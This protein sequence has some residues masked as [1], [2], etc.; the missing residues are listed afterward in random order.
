MSEKVLFVL[1]GASKEPKVID[2]LWP[3]AHSW[4]GV[5]CPPKT[6]YTFCTHIYTL[7]RDLKA[8]PDLDLLGLLKENDPDGVLSD[9]DYDTFSAIYMF[10]D[11]DGHVNMPRNEHG[12][13]HWDGDKILGEMLELFSDE[14]DHGKLFISYPMVE[15]I[16]HIDCVPKD[17]SDIVMVRCKGPHC[18]ARDTCVNRTDCL[19]V[20]VYKN[21]V[22]KEKPLLSNIARISDAKWREIICCH[23]AT[24]ALLLSGTHE[25]HGVVS[26]AEIFDMQKRVFI[27]R[28]CPQVAVLSAFPVFLY[29]YF[30]SEKL[31]KMV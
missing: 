27:S 26:Q 29:D 13:G 24:T 6:V 15:A 1:E 3:L 17:V 25:L 21:I 31:R 4:A 28:P 2:A 23:L 14:T 30:G 11:Y 12:A 5:S 22:A 20:R 10:F 7:F 19:P 8:D 16:Q 9:A 18:P